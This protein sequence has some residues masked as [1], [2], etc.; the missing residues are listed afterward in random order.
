[1]RGTNG[2]NPS[3]RAEKMRC[4][5]LTQEGRQEA[6]MDEFL[7]MPLLLLPPPSVPFRPSLDWLM[8]THTGRAI[9]FSESSHSI[10][11]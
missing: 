5:V 11:N 6:K 10:A 2:L 3:P 4:G 9:Y 1:M 8:H 7:L